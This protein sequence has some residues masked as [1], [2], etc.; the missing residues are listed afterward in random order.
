[1]S[2]TPVQHTIYFARGRTRMARV[3]L[4]QPGAPLPW[5]APQLSPQ[6]FTKAMQHILGSISPEEN[7]TDLHNMQAS[8]LIVA[9]TSNS[10]HV[11][12]KTITV[13]P[14]ILA[15]NL[16]WQI[17]GFESNPPNFLQYV[18]VTYRYVTS[19]ICRP[20]SFKMSARKLQTSKEWNE[21]SPDLV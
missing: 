5:A 2:G 16:F 19:S 9:S 15:G 6:S 20:P 12:R 1:M 14:E 18:I 4:G 10:I 7:S 17:G 13:W 8:S 21:N 11:L 3:D